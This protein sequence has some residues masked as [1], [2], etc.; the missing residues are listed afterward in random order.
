MFE[1]KI[2]A[3]RVLGCLLRYVVTISAEP[4]STSVNRCSAFLLSERDVGVA[5]DIASEPSVSQSLLL[6]LERDTSLPWN[7]YLKNRDKVS[8]RVIHLFLFVL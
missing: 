6:T 1:R 8:P 7:I 5:E 4:R 3:A 2:N